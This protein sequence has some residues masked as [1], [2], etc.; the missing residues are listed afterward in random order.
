MKKPILLMLALVSALGLRAQMTA[1]TVTTGAGYANQVWYSMENGEVMEQPK[2]DWDL[3]FDVSAFGFNIMTN[4]TTGMMLYLYPGD[5]SAFATLD[6]AGIDTWTTLYNSDTSWAYG[7]FTRSQSGLDVGWGQYSTVTHVITGDSLYVVKLADGSYQKLFIQN[8]AGGAYN[9][10]H[11]TLDN[12][13]DMTHSLAKSAFTDKLFGYFNLTSHSTIDREPVSGDWD[14]LFTQYTGYLPTPYTVSGV[15]QHPAVE[16]AQAYPVTDPGTYDAYTDHEFS[17]HINQIGW[18]WKTFDFT[19]GYII[20]DSSVYFVKNQAGDIWKVVFTGFGG[21]SNGEYHFSKSKVL[22]TAIDGLQPETFLEVYPNPAQDVVNVVGD[23]QAGVEAEMIILDLSGRMVQTE[24][25][26]S[27]GLS[28]QAFHVS[29]L[30]TGMY[31]LIIRQGS[32]TATRKLV[33]R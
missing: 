32:V 26:V 9:F 29:G 4:P 7:S 8:M 18:D 33:I 28:A 22:T 6:T 11:A 19:V 2:D 1:D 3:A 27:A 16:V 24:R 12:S 31:Q 5:T 21:S 13:M 20:Q 17:A 10:R 15:L 30:S 14:L 23:F 25:F